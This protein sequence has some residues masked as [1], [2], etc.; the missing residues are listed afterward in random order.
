M[1]SRAA[2]VAH[3]SS[4][5]LERLK[6]GSYLEFLEPYLAGETR[7]R[8]APPALAPLRAYGLLLLNMSGAPLPRELYERVA[9]AHT[10][11]SLDRS[12]RGPAPGCVAEIDKPPNAKMLAP[13]TPPLAVVVVP[14]PPDAGAPLR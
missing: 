4:V 14:P 2:Q 1:P 7:Q 3:L 12:G 5:E 10:T 8:A 13:G 9:A 11:V 6:G